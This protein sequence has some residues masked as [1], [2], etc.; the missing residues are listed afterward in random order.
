MPNYTQSKRSVKFESEMIGV[1]TLLSDNVVTFCEKQ[2][3]HPSP[4]TLAEFWTPAH[5]LRVL[6]FE[7]TFFP[8]IS[9]T[10]CYAA[11]IMF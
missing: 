10:S 2:N 3:D 5:N 9:P 7:V 6:L 11:G 1:I 4:T 8:G